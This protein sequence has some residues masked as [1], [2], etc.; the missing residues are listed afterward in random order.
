MASWHEENCYPSEAQFVPK[1]IKAGEDK[2]T[3][4]DAGVLI[5]IV[6]DS[7][8]STSFVLVLDAQNLQVMARVELNKLIPLSFARGTYKL[9]ATL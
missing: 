2:M 3:G 7:A 4:E 1:P 6:L 9:R 8:R 5:S